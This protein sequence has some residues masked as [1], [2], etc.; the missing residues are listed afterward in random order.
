[1]TF[2]RWA[3][4]AVLAAAAG[5]VSAQPVEVL[6]WWTSAGE[7]AALKELQLGLQA[8]GFAWQDSS[9]AGGDDRKRLIAAARAGKHALPAAMQ[10]H[11][12]SLRD[13]AG[14][15]ISLQPLALAGRWDDVVPAPVRDSAKVDGQWLGAPTNVHRTNW[16]WASRK[17]FAQAGLVPP[18]TFAELIAV[19]ERLARD[20]H[21]ALAHGGEPWQDALLLDNAVLSAGGPGFYR[22]ALLQLDREALTGPQMLKAF[23]QLAALRRFMDPNRQGRPWNFA[24]AMVAADKAG[25]QVMGDWAKGELTRGGKRAG[26]DFLCFP[27]PGT[28]GSFVFVSDMFAMP[29]ADARSAAGQMAL[30]D[31]AMDPQVQRRF[32][33]AKGSIP[34]RTDV[35][36]EGYDACAL[37]AATAF[38]QSAQRG[39]LVSRFTSEVSEP[40]RNAVAQAASEFLSGQGT[41]AEGVQR[42][43]RLVAAAR[44]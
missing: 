2:S 37:Q 17:L 30:A 19:A 27:Y 35:A 14:Q 6:H 10:V 41:P 7:A 44:R 4:A 28:Q 8:R 26:E 43:G 1:M 25:M 23:E 34:A 12:N 20:G 32:S 36:M 13:S 18:T 33:L 11:A 39:T 29:R 3:G 24:S 9:V 38:R 42:L 5:A 16:I 40:V 15:W 22:K 31:A 21:V